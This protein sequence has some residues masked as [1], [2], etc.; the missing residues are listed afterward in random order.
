MYTLKQNIETCL[1]GLVDKLQSR[2]V[3]VCVVTFLA[4]RKRLG[5]KTSG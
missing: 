5:M 4:F 3:C 2:N 1:A